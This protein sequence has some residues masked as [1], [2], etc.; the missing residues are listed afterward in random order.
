MFPWLRETGRKVE[1]INAY[2]SYC[3]RSDTKIWQSGLL[4]AMLWGGHF[5]MP[6]T[7]L[8][9]ILAT[10]TVFLLRS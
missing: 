9:G 2:H 8:I 4:S 1:K 5:P 3:S 10:T 6:L 7:G